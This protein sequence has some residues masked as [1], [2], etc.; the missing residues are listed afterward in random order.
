VSEQLTSYT[1]NKNCCPEGMKFFL[2]HVEQGKDIVCACLRESAVREL[3]R[4]MSTDN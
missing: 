1:R 4:R 2:T 3:S